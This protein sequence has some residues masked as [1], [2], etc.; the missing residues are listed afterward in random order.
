[1]EN[2]LIFDHEPIATRLPFR[3]NDIKK[4]EDNTMEDRIWYAILKDNEDN[5]WGTGT[6]DRDEAIHML[7]ETREFYPDALIAVIL[8]GPP[9]PVCIEEI[10]DIEPTLYV[11][12]LA[13]NLIEHADTVP[14]H[15]DLDTAAQLISGLDP[16]DLP[17][18]IDLTPKSLMDAMNE[19][20]RSG[21]ANEDD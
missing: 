10:R 11:S 3:Y 18:Y 12:D 2:P 13:L 19:I 5:D 21:A 14:E 6:F 16:D 1:M 15:I 4:E 20:I 8:D 17:R 7:R 9:D